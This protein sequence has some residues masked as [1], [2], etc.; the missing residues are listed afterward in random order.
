MSLIL[1]ALN[2]ADSERKNQ[3]AVPD[4]TTQHTPLPLMPAVQTRRP[5]LWLLL[6]LV[7]GAL[8][9]A[10]VLWLWR[11]GPAA[12][13]S[14]PGGAQVAA[15]PATPAMPLST[16]TIPVSTTVA[17]TTAA[18]KTATEPALVAP[19]NTAAPSAE[20]VPVTAPPSRDV[21]D[22]YAAETAAA[23]AVDASVN[24]LYAAE[25][26]P[27]SA[28]IVD[29]FAAQPA[30]VP[31]AEVV[32]EAARSFD[33]MTHIQD[34]NELPWNS[35][36]QIPTISYQRHDYLAGGLSSVVINGQTQGVGNIVATGQFVVVDILVDGVVLKH[37][38]HTFKLRALNG[39]INM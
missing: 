38:N 4:L 34:F 29:P 35:K 21:Q 39:W 2:R 6:A 12:E 22:L 9:I 37:G 27:E 13:L 19:A 15:A 20:P 26:A 14:A 3:Q 36:Q 10:L 23:P 33:S 31:P 1:D 7:L 17:P 30:A 24:E 18:P 11:S 32:R 25:V 28:S 16:P 8:L 5:L